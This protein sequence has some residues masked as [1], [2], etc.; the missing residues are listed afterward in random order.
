MVSV[1][2][3][4]LRITDLPECKHG[5]ILGWTFAPP[6]SISPPTRVLRILT[7]KELNAYFLNPFGWVVLAF[8]A[9]VQG[10]F[11]FLVFES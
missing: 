8:V 4:N 7:R 9:L 11:P 6:R 3:P 1:F 2:I 5:A 10:A